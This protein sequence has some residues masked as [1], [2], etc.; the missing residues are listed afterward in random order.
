MRV[1]G[2]EYKNFRHLME[3]NQFVF[4]T[5][6]VMK[7]YQNRDPEWKLVNMELLGNLRSKKAKNAIIHLNTDKINEITVTELFSTI[8]A[9]PGNLPLRLKIYDNLQTGLKADAIVKNFKISISDEALKAF[10][11]LENIDFKIT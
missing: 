1:F 10:R 4:I 9:H 7:G 5:A 3:A 2:E 11:N 8:S 6:K